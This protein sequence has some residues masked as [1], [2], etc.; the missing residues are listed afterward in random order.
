MNQ[1]TVG[2]QLS[3]AARFGSIASGLQI[4]GELSPLRS[5]PLNERNGLLASTIN[6]P[7]R[8]IVSNCEQSSHGCHAYDFLPWCGGT[9]SIACLVAIDDKRHP[10]DSTELLSPELNEKEEIIC[11][12]D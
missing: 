8:R 7:S 2:L 5:E 9:V 12:E 4:F 1:T 10:Q 11:D 3:N 6:F